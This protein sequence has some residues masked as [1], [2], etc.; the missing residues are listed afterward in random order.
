MYSRTMEGENSTTKR[1]M[2]TEAVLVVMCSAG[3]VISNV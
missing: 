3:S 1:R 2:S